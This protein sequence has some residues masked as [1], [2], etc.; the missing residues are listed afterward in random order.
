[1]ILIIVSQ[2]YY[3]NK[4]KDFSI[5]HGFLF[6]EEDKLGNLLKSSVE[7]LDLNDKGLHIICN[8]SSNGWKYFEFVSSFYD[9]GAGDMSYR[10]YRYIISRNDHNLPPCLVEMRGLIESS[11]VR[12]QNHPKFS[13]YYFVKGK[14]IKEV[15]NDELITY[16]EKWGISQFTITPQFIFMKEE[17]LGG[18][19][20][21]NNFI[22]RFEEILSILKK[23]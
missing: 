4:L 15:F 19:S 11:D 16:F 7:N 5:K 8:N 18:F 14:D 12:F 3:G 9:S 10:L 17:C 20:R 21:F 23:L 22:R 6:K 1:M 2:K 13:K